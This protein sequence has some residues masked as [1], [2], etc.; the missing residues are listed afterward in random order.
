MVRRPQV[1]NRWAGG[2][3]GAEISEEASTVAGIW[4]SVLSV[5]FPTGQS[6]RYIMTLM[7]MSRGGGWVDKGIVWSNVAC[8]TLDQ[9]I[10]PP[11]LFSWFDVAP[12][13]SESLWFSFCIGTDILESQIGWTQST[14]SGLAS[15]AFRPQGSPPLA[16]LLMGSN[17]INCDLQLDTCVVFWGIED[18][19]LVVW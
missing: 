17:H 10:W 11:P 18:H 9:T 13:V 3:G 16:T 14:K 6:S 8:T 4:T 5:D 1:E 15:K 7:V 12:V 19:C 2:A